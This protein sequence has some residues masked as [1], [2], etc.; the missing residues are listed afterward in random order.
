M[1]KSTNRSAG[2]A[3]AGNEALAR[4]IAIRRS[5]GVF[6]GWTIGQIV[7]HS[8]R[9][10]LG[11]LFEATPYLDYVRRCVGGAE[12]EAAATVIAALRCDPRAVD[13]EL[14]DVELYEL[15]MVAARRHSVHQPACLD[16]EAA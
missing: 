13:G 3:A 4:A 5:R 15:A 16:G 10:G 11:T 14:V 8:H 1:E 6:S 7:R 2:G 12:G 9:V